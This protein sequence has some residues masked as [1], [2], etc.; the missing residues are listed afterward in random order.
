MF[1][2]IIIL[3]NDIV[4]HELHFFLPAFLASFFP[5]FLSSSGPA[6]AAD[7]ALAAYNFLRASRLALIYKVLLWLI[8]LPRPS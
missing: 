3:L 7:A 8:R 5:P 2:C 4:S 1:E 6:A